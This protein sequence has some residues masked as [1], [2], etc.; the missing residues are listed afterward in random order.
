MGIKKGP[1]R[2]A[3]SIGK[4]DRCQRDNKKTPENTPLLRPLI[5]IR[6]DINFIAPKYLN[7]ILYLFY[8]Q[9]TVINNNILSRAL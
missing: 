1:K 2:I 4:L 7:V 8:L 5:S 9:K 3:K 6:K